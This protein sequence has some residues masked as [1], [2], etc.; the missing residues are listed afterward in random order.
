MISPFDSIDEVNTQLTACKAGLLDI[1]QG[2]TFRLQTGGSERI[3]TGEDLDKLQ[4]YIVFL[5][6]ER[7][8]FQRKNHAAIVHGR[9]SR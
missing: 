6:K 7:A 8:K 2:K 5:S 4:N 1:M 3:W 9:P